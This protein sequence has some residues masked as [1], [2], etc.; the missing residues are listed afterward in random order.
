MLNVRF[1][2]V[3]W[4]GHSDG[5]AGCPG[6]IWNTAHVHTEGGVVGTLNAACCFYCIPGNFKMRWSRIDKHII[7][8]SLYIFVYLILRVKFHFLFYF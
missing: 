2:S 7:Y 6:R 1:Y 3:L 4:S 5:N 8:H